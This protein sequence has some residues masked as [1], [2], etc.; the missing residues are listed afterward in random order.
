VENADI[1]QPIF[2]G[3]VLNTISG[4]LKIYAPNRARKRVIE[5]GGSL[6]EATQ[7][8]DVESV[9]IYQKSKNYAAL[10]GWYLIGLILAIHGEYP[11]IAVT[12]SWI[13]TGPS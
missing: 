11:P 9:L 2:V 5:S 1:L 6:V 8:Y 7:A 13:Y 3:W 10:G 12:L 4:V